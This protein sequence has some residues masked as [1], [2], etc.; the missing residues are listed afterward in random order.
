MRYDQA[1]WTRIYDTLE[2][3]VARIAVQTGK[4]PPLELYL[5]IDRARFAIN[6]GRQAQAIEILDGIMARLADS[7]GPQSR[8]VARGGGAG[9]ASFADLE[10]LSSKMTC[11]TRFGSAR[12]EITGDAEEDPPAPT[13][14]G[15][16]NTTVN[17]STEFRDIEAE[18]VKLFD[19]AVIRPEK[20]AE[21]AENADRIVANR[22]VYERI[23]EET[24]VPWFFTGLIHG[25]EC[26]FSLKKHLHNGDSLNAK[27]WQVPAGRPKDGDPP[28][29]FEASACDALA[30]DK[31]TG[32]NDWSLA[33]IL[34]RLE[35]YN[36]MAYRKKFGIASP[37]L[38]SF[39][40]H[41]VRGKY[42]RDGVWD[43]NAES[44]QVGAA[45]MLRDLIDRGA[46]SIVAP[47]AAAASAAAATAPPP[48]PAPAPGPA[49][50]P[51]TAPAPIPAPA[52]VATGPSPA[53]APVTT[54]EILPPSLAPDRGRA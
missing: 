43:P 28:F 23:S 40:N 48:A 2:Q 31:F 4:R 37:Y 50:A 54:P 1:Y 36:G 49:P 21:V 25:M 5:D 11:E 3:D 9:A 38:W 45:A 42:V 53:P 6:D 15:R 44:K 30:Y 33:E 10:A 14:D 24:Q 12:L 32:L 35:R 7:A 51:V 18:Y 27:T 47:A 46:V 22:A 39:T 8:A 41:H 29:T 26:S 20:K 52:P 17:R 16:S 13:R 19:T 34:Y